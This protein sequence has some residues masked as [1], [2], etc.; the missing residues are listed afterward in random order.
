[1]LRE[2][3]PAIGGALVGVAKIIR[4]LIGIPVTVGPVII[5]VT[6]VIGR[7]VIVRHM[8]VVHAR[9]VH[10]R[11]HLRVELGPEVAHAAT[12]VTHS[13]EVAT[14][15]PATE[16][17]KMTTTKAAARHRIGRE[18]ERTHGNR[19]R[20]RKSRAANHEFSSGNLTPRAGFS[21]GV[22]W[23]RYRRRYDERLSAAG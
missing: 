5:R 6:A 8:A 15:E 18:P 16:A 11:T 4:P 1:M 21:A 20:Q 13:A 17:A 12:E 3:I 10:L 14:A 23:L 2:I 9:L 19:C 22:R 7:P